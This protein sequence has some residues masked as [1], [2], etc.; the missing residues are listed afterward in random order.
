[1]G[2][3]AKTYQKIEEAT[4]S[5]S[6]KVEFDLQE[7]REWAFNNISYN[8]RLLVLYAFMKEHK[9]KL[10]LKEK[11]TSYP[12]VIKSYLGRTSV[13]IGVQISRLNRSIKRSLEMNQQG[14]FHPEVK[15][16]FERPLQRKPDKALERDQH[17]YTGCV[18][19]KNAP[20][21]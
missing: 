17:R 14:Q 3:L 12:K 20:K 9:A 16:P 6:D 8:R 7:F 10:L 5:Q 15:C 13:M 2:P 18:K 21:I 4:T 11:A 1:M 19:K